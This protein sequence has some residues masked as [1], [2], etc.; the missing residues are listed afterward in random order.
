[1]TGSYMMAYSASSGF[2]PTEE[3]SGENLKCTTPQNDPLVVLAECT[4]V[5]LEDRTLATARRVAGRLLDGL[6]PVHWVQPSHHSDYI[7][8]TLG[9]SH[10]RRANGGFIMP[11]KVMVIH[12]LALSFFLE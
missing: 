6:D 12:G 10:T 11:T 1:M 4:R 9:R 7:S 8:P 3:G 5:M 2:L